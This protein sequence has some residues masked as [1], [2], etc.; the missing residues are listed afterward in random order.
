MKKLNKLVAILVAL[1]MMMALAVTSAFALDDAKKATT[2]ADAVLTKTFQT[3]AGVKAPSANFNF[4]F[5]KA[6]GTNA[7]TPDVGVQTIHFDAK[8]AGGEQVGYKNLGEIFTITGEDNKIALPHAGTYIYTVTENDD[9]ATA[10][11]STW[12]KAG[13]AT[14]QEAINFSKASY[15]LRIYV[16]NGE[17]AG[18]LAIQ[19]VTVEKVLN[20]NGT[21][22]TDTGDAKKVPPTKP[23]GDNT[24]SGWEYKNVYSKTIT[25]P[26]GDTNGAFNVQKVVDGKNAD[27]TTQFNF[28]GKLT[29][30]DTMK[31]N[32]AQVFTASYPTGKTATFTVPANSTESN[33]EVFKLANGEKLVFATFPAGA[34]FTVTEELQNQTNIQYNTRYTKSAALKE[35]SSTPITNT[36]A[37]EGVD[38][39]AVIGAINEQDALTVTN[40]LADKEVEPEGILISNLPYIALALVAIGGLV[41]Y[42]V[43]RRRNADEA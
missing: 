14:D 27:K 40:K 25:P 36:S 13:S 35:G 9:K 24:K 22:N 34:T 26:E 7:D 5:E 18:T 31:K 12:E 6:T 3:P 39:T 20:D 19:A 23:A 2:L 11:A 28:K 30:P 29:I 15:T 16:V 38:Y 37:A 41:A 10:N 1:A 32:E 33:E 17:T 21:S 4:K 42:V 43:V 8:D